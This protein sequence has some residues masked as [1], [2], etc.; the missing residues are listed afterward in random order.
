MRSSVSFA[1]L[2]YSTTFPC[3]STV[4][5]RLSWPELAANMQSL[6]SR[7][8]V[9]DSTKVN[10]KTYL[11]STRVRLESRSWWLEGPSR[12]HPHDPT[13]QNPPQKELSPRKSHQAT[14]GNEFWWMGFGMAGKGMILTLWVNW[15]IRVEITC[16]KRKYRRKQWTKL[17][18]S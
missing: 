1:K 2:F 14:G 18:T 5:C 15:T 13:R 6:H 4:T 17:G 11:P 3:L 10:Q 16:C 12:L 8:A 7:L 9:R